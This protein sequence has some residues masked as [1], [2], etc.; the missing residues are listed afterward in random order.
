MSL[1]PFWY[2]TIFGAYYFAGSFLAAS[3]CSPSS[4]SATR[5]EQRLFGGLVTRHHT[6]NLGKLMLAFTAF[7]A[8]IALL[9]VHAHLDRQHPRG[10][11]LVRASG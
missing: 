6:H 5:N 1:D 2:S 4:P 3:R 10:G 7:W 9:P 8:Y 11:G